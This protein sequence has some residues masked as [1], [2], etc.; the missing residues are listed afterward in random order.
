MKG[1]WDR[2]V[3]A[4][5]DKELTAQKKKKAHPITGLFVPADPRM[6]TY[7]VTIPKGSE[8]QAIASHCKRVLFEG[9]GAEVQDREAE[10]CKGRHVVGWCD[11][12][13]QKRPKPFAHSAIH[14]ERVLQSLGELIYGDV[15]ITGPLDT[16]TGHYS[17][18]QDQ[19]E[20]F[21][22]A[23]KGFYKKNQKSVF[24]DTPPIHYF[25]Y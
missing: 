25:Y 1:L 17:S 23:T 16:A 9:G 8:R 20:V 3:S 14:N 12:R 10:T 18:Y 19:E 22:Q 15:L 21:S 4:A 7:V 24:P 11:E 13:L 2:V 5:V 6:S